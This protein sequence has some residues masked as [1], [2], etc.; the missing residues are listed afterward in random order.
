MIDRIFKNYITTII[1]LIIFGIGSYTFIDKTIDTISYVSLITL[2]M[3]FIRA[4][5]S[6]IGFSS[7][8]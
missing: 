3:T 4:K 1:G 5:D 7:K 8:E 2:A 6:L